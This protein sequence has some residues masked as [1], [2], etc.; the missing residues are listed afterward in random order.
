MK[1]F[2]QLALAVLGGIVIGS[3][4]VSCGRQ[5]DVVEGD[6]DLTYTFLSGERGS[7]NRLLEVQVDGPILNNSSSGFGGLSV[8]ATYGYD[9]QRLLERVSKDKRVKGIF[10]RLST[11]GGTIVGSNAIYEGLVNYRK[12]TQKPVLAY[13]EGLSASGGVMSMV[14]ADKIYAAPGSLIGSIGVIGG[15]LTYFDNPVALDGGLLGGGIVTKN[16]IQQTVIS[17]GRSKDLGNPFRKPTEE[18]LRVLR[19]GVNN[20]YN[21]FVRHVSKTR[22]ISEQTIRSDMGALIF[23]NQT[24]QKYKLIDGTKSR[25]E[26][27]AELA[28]QANVGSN[29]QLVRTGRR[30]GLLSALLSSTQ[31]AITPEQA[32]EMVSR[33]LCQTTA[34]RVALVYYGDVSSLCPKQ[35]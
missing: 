33:D 34:S 7:P 19:Q 10:L 24:A 21:Q 5:S 4:F 31:P 14:G 2:L 18:E 6:N 3:S 23:D 13:V 20:E 29:Y 1:R 8:G 32:R 22:G 17:A 16:G 12:A 11:P 9:V 28:K 27:I 25:T 35:P 30:G 15:V 26:A